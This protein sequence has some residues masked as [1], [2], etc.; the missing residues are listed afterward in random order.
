MNTVQAALWLQYTKALYIYTKSLYLKLFRSGLQLSSWKVQCSKPSGRCRSSAFI[1]LWKSNVKVTGLCCRHALSFQQGDSDQKSVSY[2]SKPSRKKTLLL[3]DLLGTL[4]INSCCKWKD[5]CHKGKVSEVCVW[6]K[7]IVHW[8]MWRILS[9]LILTLLFWYLPY[10]NVCFK[11]V[12]CPCPLSF[13]AI[14]QLRHFSKYFIL[15]SKEES[16]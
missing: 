4:C 2:S 9:T 5:V 7:G 14:E 1:W 8:K 13:Y 11:L 16:K 15:C 10:F 12:P 6:I 3:I